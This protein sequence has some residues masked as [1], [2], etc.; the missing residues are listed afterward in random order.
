M[1]GSG[2]RVAFVGNRGEGERVVVDGIE[3]E[4]Y[5][6]TRWPVT[7]SRN[8]A[9]V[10]FSAVSQGW[11]YVVVNGKRGPPFRGFD[12]G[13]VLSADGSTAAYIVNNGSEE[14]AVVGESAGP[15]FDEISGLVLS[16][17]GRTFT[18]RVDDH[19]ILNGTKI[20]PF[21]GVSNPFLTPDGK[22]LAFGAKI[23]GRWHLVVGDQRIPVSRPVHS[24]FVTSDGSRWGY[25]TQPERRFE[26]VVDEAVLGE[27]SVWKQVPRFS[28]DGKTV[29]FSD[30]NHVF[31]GM[32]KSS[33]YDQVGPL[34]FSPDGKRV[35][36]GARRGRELL[37]VV[38][39]VE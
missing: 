9:A 1:S 11:R 16:D 10:A 6:E 18:Y 30:A 17:D 25:V 37:R 13:L 7:V 35:L 36:F 21:E 3:G 28:P 26:V 24:V 27:C 23:R 29:A 12:S 38:L 32:R 20:G 19:I 15:V 22:I 39:P 8:G 14:Y 31:V 5:K 4:P 34:T 2:K 33:R